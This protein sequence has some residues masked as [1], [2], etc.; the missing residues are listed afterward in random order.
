MKVIWAMLVSCLAL[1][2]LICL[3]AATAQDDLQQSQPQF[4]TIPLHGN[5]VENV[6]RESASGQTVP[7]WTYS[8]E[9]PSLAARGFDFTLALVVIKKSVPLD[10]DHFGISA[11]C[12][13]CC[14]S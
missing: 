11:F 10:S 5:T 12:N 6:L 8:V 9:V 2:L 7:L 13:I 4:G 3:P 1:S 14:L